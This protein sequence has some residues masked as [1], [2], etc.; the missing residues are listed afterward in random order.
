MQ[1]KTFML[2]VA[3][4]SQAEEELNRFLRG[5]RVLQIERHF[6]PD[7]GGYWAVLVEYVDGDPT[8]MVPP[9]RRKD[10]QDPTKELTDEERQRYEH[11]KQVRHQLANKNAIPAYLIFTNEELAIL[12]R[13]PELSA[14]TIKDV[15]GIAPTRLKQYIEHF[16]VVSDAEESKQLDAKNSSDRE[17]A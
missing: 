7:N 15:K 14:E 5:H 17:S 11:F 4:A 2:P 10:K 9:A 12:S 8:D 16:Y 6:C 1:I 3:S 13:I